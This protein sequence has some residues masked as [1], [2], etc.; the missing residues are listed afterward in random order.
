LF[1]TFVIVV[2]LLLAWFPHAKPMAMAK[3]DCG[4]A[5]TE[6]MASPDCGNTGGDDCWTFCVSAWAD[7]VQLPVIAR[8]SFPRSWAW[9]DQT[10]PGLGPAPALG[11]PRS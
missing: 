2:A 11:P 7:L 4:A 3:P 6:Q 1:A 9:L 10:M 8:P 5:M